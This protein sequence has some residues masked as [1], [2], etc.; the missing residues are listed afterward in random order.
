M[1]F[2]FPGKLNVLVFDLKPYLNEISET[3]GLVSVFVNPKYV[4]EIRKKFK[5]PTRLET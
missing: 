5:V 3:K 4:D 1:D 2:D